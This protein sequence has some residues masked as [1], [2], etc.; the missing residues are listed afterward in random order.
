MRTCFQ[1]LLFASKFNL[2]RYSTVEMAHRMLRKKR[3][4]STLCA[5]KR[6][7]RWEHSP[8][9]R[10]LMHAVSSRHRRRAGQERFRAW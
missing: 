9:H 4:E 5:W 10:R 3:M 7:S 2:R 6:R 8:E 1:S